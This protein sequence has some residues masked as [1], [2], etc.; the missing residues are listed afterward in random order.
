MTRFPEGDEI[1][2]EA[3]A[4]VDRAIGGINTLHL[5]PLD[6]NIA[7]TVDHL[8]VAIRLLEQLW[9]DAQDGER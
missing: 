1:I 5:G 2:Q 6:Y 3:L 9:R 8:L 7:N 4:S